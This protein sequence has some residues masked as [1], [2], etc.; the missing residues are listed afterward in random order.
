MLM[1]KEVEE[2]DPY[3]YRLLHHKPLRFG[4]SGLRD[5]DSKLTDMQI[6][7][8]TK[9]F[10]NYLFSIS[11]E[12]GGIR[13]GCKVAL[14]GDFRPTTPRI[15]FAIAVAIIDSGCF[16]DYCG[17][18]PTPTVSL[19]GF[20]NK[21]PSI[22]ITGSHNPYGQNGVK[23]NKIDGE[24]LK[25]DENGIL[26]EIHKVREIEYKKSWRESMFNKNGFFKDYHEISDVYAALL[27]LR[28]WKALKKELINDK[29]KELYI[30]RYKKAFGKSLIGEKIVFYCQTAIGRDIIPKV[31]EELGLEVIK[32][33]FVDEKIEFV[34][35]DTEDMKPW[36]LE[37]MANLAIKNRCF[38]TVTADGDSDRPAVLFVKKDSFGNYLYK[39]GKI[40]YSYIKGDKL[41]V[42]AALFLKPDFVSVPVSF[43]HKASQV[44]TNNG[45]EVK[46]TKIGSPFV[47]KAANDK[48]KLIKEEL[49]KK[50]IIISEKEL[51][52]K[53]GLYAFEVNGGA[54]LCS[55]RQLEYGK[56]SPLP[57]R[58][59]VLPIICALAL[60]KSKNI[61]IEEL[62][63]Q[64]FSNEYESHSYAGLVENLSK[65]NITSGLERYSA[66]IGKKI[67]EDF[68]LYNKEIIEVIFNKS[69]IDFKNH[70][71]EIILIEKNIINNAKRNKEI[72]I[73]YIKVFLEIEEIDIV[74]INYLDGIRVYLSNSE[75][76]HFRP[77]GNSSQFRIYIESHNE[78]RAIKLVDKATMPH[79]GFLVK[80]INDFIDGNLGL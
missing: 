60:A 66:E 44:L 75:I 31:L 57:T 22:M 76:I 77:S 9:G 80:F 2:D 5:E 34:P 15:L 69:Q 11:F 12:N 53:V 35:V 74:K 30:E 37:K 70:K 42:L 48:L 56:L 61:D 23:F 49:L 52:E 64:T 45:I 43:N 58:D 25:E 36:I 8:S 16:V 40:Q 79:N 13:K 71:E 73:S 51:L 7:I 41:N 17:K 54:I 55:Y 67:I 78:E 1:E 65:E 14:A 28:A 50:G 63:L 4:T 59:A 46:L 47:I 26:E 18:I 3:S 32:E 29:A 38:I 24:V 39:N 62:M 20:Y 72:L 33:E 19:W 27:L 6:Y 68:S 21:I 10:L